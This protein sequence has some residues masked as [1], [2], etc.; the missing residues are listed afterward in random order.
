MAATGGGAGRDDARSAHA[1]AAR[2]VS[3]RS[4]EAWQQWRTVGTSDSVQ[5]GLR[6][7]LGSAVGEVSEKG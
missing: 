6:V 7:S 2:R 3:V 5:H 4:G 1:G